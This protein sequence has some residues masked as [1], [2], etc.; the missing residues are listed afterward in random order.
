MYDWAEGPND[1]DMT[2]ISSQKSP[3][4][5]TTVKYWYQFSAFC[6]GDGMFFINNA[7]NILLSNLILSK[8]GWGKMIIHKDF[9]CF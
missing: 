4:N 9:F 5:M 1:M 6:D 8:H 7:Q 3:G 2:N